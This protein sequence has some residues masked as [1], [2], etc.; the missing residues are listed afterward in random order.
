MKKALLLAAAALMVPSI[1]LAAKPSPSSKSVGH[2]PKVAYII[3]GTLSAYTPYD[4]STST[5]GSI[6]IFVKRANKPGRPLRV[7]KGLT[8]TFPVG[9]HTRVSLPDGASTINDNDR[10]IVKVRA[11]WR[12]PPADLAATLQA[13]TARQIVDHGTS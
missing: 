13:T 2:A 3:K 7:L 10:G 6:T 8:L 11:A 12:I 4:S 9:A 5:N 1:A